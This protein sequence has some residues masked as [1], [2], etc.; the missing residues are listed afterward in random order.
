MCL[1]RFDTDTKTA[2]LDLYTKVDADATPA[3]AADAEEFTVNRELNDN[4]VTFTLKYK[5]QVQRANFKSEELQQFA[6]MSD[7]QVQ[8]HIKDTLRKVI[9]RNIK[10]LPF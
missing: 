9:D 4:S 1:N 6:G 8:D 10:D 2:F 7:A 3:P 5:G